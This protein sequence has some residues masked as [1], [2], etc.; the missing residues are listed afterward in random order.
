MWHLV[1]ELSQSNVVQVLCE[2][3]EDDASSGVE[4]IRLKGKVSSLSCFSKKV[5]QWLKKNQRGNR[6]VHSHQSLGPANIF[7]FHSTPH[8][9]GDD[10]KWWKKISPSWWI[11][12]SI[13]R[14]AMCTNNFSA[15]VPVSEVVSSQI[16]SRYP[17]VEDKI[18]DPIPPGVNPVTSGKVLTSNEWTMGFIG[19]EWERKGLRKVVEVFR[20]VASKNGKA[21]LVVAGMP[22]EEVA[23]LIVGIEPRVD[24]LGWINDQNDFYGQI[25]LLF[26]PARLEAFGMVVTEAMARN[27]PV[28]VSNQVGA[29]S[30]V[31]PEDGRIVSLTAPTSEW[32]KAVMELLAAVRQPVATY[33][34][35][36]AQMA[37]EYCVLYEK[38]LYR[39]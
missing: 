34:R 2:T 35:S 26:H 1:S 25:N 7:T 37:S 33:S 16:A 5:N 39:R 14:R 10:K 12:E 20:V 17:G 30:E 9:W 3:Q 23:S 36:W 6:V 22:R 8:G 4:I 15:I 38:H 19:R 24:V 11:N 21:R 27:I 31:R 13:Y 28:L 32:V 18:V 29:S